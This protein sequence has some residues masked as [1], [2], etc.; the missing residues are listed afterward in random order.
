MGG[1]AFGF[2]A[3]NGNPLMSTIPSEP[4]P[5]LCGVLGAIVTVTMFAVRCA[6]AIFKEACDGLVVLTAVSDPAPPGVTNA[7]CAPGSKAICGEVP[8]FR[9]TKDTGQYDVPSEGANPGKQME[10]LCEG[11]RLT[12]NPALVDANA[13]SARCVKGSMPTEYGLGDV[14]VLV[15]PPDGGIRLLSGIV[16]SSVP[17]GAVSTARVC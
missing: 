8:V 5:R 1:F 13:T 12:I 9:S 15:E 10:G 11:S 7:K 2:P 14:F 6:D 17:D 16:S 3:P 4:G